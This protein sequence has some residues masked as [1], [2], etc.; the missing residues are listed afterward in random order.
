[1]NR[2]AIA[3]E[4]EQWE[5]AALYLLIGMQKAIEAL[6]PETVEALLELIEDEEEAAPHSSHRQ[7]R[8]G[9]RRRR[10]G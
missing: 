1:V 6:P 7:R 2:L 3:I 5:V 8:P 4:K 10:H 9:R